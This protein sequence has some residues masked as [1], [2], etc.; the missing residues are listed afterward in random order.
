MDIT[1]KA[2]MSESLLA[3]FNTLEKS[4][5]YKYNNVITRDSKKDDGDEFMDKISKIIGN[6]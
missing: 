4:M 2:F 6:F 1:S 3:F 5:K